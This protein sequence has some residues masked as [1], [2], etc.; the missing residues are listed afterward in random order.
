MT[1]NQSE[2]LV[3]IEDSL[4]RVCLMQ[5]ALLRACARAAIRSARY[6]WCQNQ[7]CAAIACAAR[8]GG[9][10]RN[11]IARAHAVRLN[12]RGVNSAAS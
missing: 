11:W 2:Y 10:R 6:C 12:A 5:Q 3:A 1:V 7:F 4:L 8:G 9:V